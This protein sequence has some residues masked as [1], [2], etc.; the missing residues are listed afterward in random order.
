MANSDSRRATLD[1]VASICM[2]A[3]SVAMVGYLALLVFGGWSQSA[4]ATRKP[5]VP[6]A[7]ESLMPGALTVSIEGAPRLGDAGATVTIVEYSD[8]D[9]PF[10]RKYVRETFDFVKV[11]IIDS[12]KA[13]YVVQQMP[14]VNVHTRALQAAAA[15]ACAGAQQRFWEMRAA[16]YKHEKLDESDLLESAT[17]VGL[18][19]PLFSACK[20]RAEPTLR[21][22]IDDARRLGVSSE[23]TFLVGTP[24]PDGTV[25]VLRRINGAQPASVLTSAVAAVAA[26]AKR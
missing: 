14:L 20:T 18:N 23:P 2:A 5:P 1:T 8:F 3:A 19:L 9:C 26:I 21:D 12:G 13:T 22:Q 25:G 7:V 15:A 17:Q 4:T 10:C 16:L 24:H 11:A 6:A